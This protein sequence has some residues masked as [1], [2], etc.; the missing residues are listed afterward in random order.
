[1]ETLQ[2]L[3]G[4]RLGDLRD[5]LFEIEYDSRLKVSI[6]CRNFEVESTELALLPNLSDRQLQFPLINEFMIT[7]GERAI[8]L[9]SKP[10]TP[11]NVRG[12]FWAR[13]DFGSNEEYVTDC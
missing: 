11:K 9:L 8:S 3:H 5:D 7:L 4:W 13:V 6:V 12:L 2:Q 10:K 1:M